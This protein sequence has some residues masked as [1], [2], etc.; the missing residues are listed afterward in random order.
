M[1]DRAIV[2]ACANPVPEIYPCD[3]KEAGACIVAT[4]RSDFPN[5]VNNSLCFP[6]LLKGCL[7]VHASRVTD[8]MAAAAAH[9]L[10]RVQEARGLDADHILPTLD[11]QEVFPREAAEV[12]AQAV[13]DGVAR[14]PMDPEEVFR[15]ADHDIRAHREILQLL[16]GKGFI[17]PPPERMIRE[18]LEATLAE[19]R[20]ARPGADAKLAAVT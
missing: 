12:A 14:Q 20:G 7:L 16:E 17:Q 2:F 4:G 1:A 18:V 11:D 8:G 5:Q 3:A 10:A 13:A 19:V 15:K 6:G 9:C